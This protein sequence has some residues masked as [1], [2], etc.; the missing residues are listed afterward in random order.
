[1]RVALFWE[2]TATTIERAALAQVA[3]GGRN[4]SEIPVP[5]LPNSQAPGALQDALQAQRRA[6]AERARCLA[7]P[8]AEPV[9]SLPTAPNQ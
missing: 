6:F 7:E 4:C 5:P 3:G 1:M 2:M 8:A 9:R